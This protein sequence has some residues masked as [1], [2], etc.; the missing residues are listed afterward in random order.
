VHYR[1]VAGCVS[2]VM[3]V[4]VKGLSETPGPTE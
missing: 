2:V 3:N 1:V 4:Q